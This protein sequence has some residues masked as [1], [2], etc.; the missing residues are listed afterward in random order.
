MSKI[1]VGVGE[2]FPVEDPPPPSPPPSEEVRQRM[3]RHWRWHRWLHIATRIAFPALIVAAI[4][5]MFTGPHYVPTGAAA[6]IRPYPYHF[7][8][9]PFFPILFFVLLFA[10]FRRRGCYGGWGYWHHHHHHY[11]HRHGDPREEA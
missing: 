8:F 10:L 9:F 4:V 6:D 1:G 7:F 11:H 3:E 2:E 5:W